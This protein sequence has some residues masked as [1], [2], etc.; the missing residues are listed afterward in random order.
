MSSLSPPR[1]ACL[2]LTLWLWMSVEGE[3]S[4]RLRINQLRLI[5]THNSYHLAPDTV[6]TGLISWVR[7]A[8][9]SALE[10][11]HRPLREQLDVLRM[12]HFELD[13]Y[14]D[15]DGKLFRDP[16]SVR[17]AAE[18][19]VEVPR[20]DSHGRLHTPGI[21]IL[22]T[23]DFDART[24][25]YTL[26]DALNELKAWSDANPGHVPLFVLLEL[27]SDSFWPPTRPLKWDESGLEELEST[28]LAS[29]SRD[30]ILKP[31]DIR[32]RKAS[33]RD[34]VAGIGW[35]ALEDHRGQF[36]FLLDNEDSVR[37]AYLSKSETLAGRL[38]FV[39]VPPKH[40]AAAWMKRNDPVGQYDE[41]VSLT[42]DGFL[43]RTRADSGTT[44][45]RSNTIARRDRA[46][47]SGAQLISTDYPEPNLRF[48][49]YHVPQFPLPE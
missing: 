18:Q 11:S 15:P 36:V 29:L 6:A 25:V 21:K 33:L 9:A 46:I 8:E 1:T 32:G 30:R 7:P 31:D 40:P 12:R 20:H 44:E 27:K 10:Y 39:S 47:A 42:R 34:A 41:I 3:S 2:I 38:L 24:T 14:L 4:E 22:H 16:L 45:A 26:S 35:P 49:T 37:D 17:T 13:L 23:P 48:S 43:V 28:I 5:G 19:G